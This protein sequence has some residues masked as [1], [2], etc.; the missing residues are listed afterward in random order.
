ISRFIIND[1]L[2]RDKAVPTPFILPISATI[3]KTHQQ[4][5]AYDEILETFSRAFMRHYADAW[6]FGPEKAAEDGVRHNLQFDAWEDARHAWR[7]PDLTRHAEYL[8]DIVRRTLEDD[9]RHEADQLHRLRTARER[10]KQILEGPD[11]DIDRIIRSVRENDGKVSRKLTKEFPA[12]D[13]AQVSE[14][15]GKII[16]DIFDLN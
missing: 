15:I 13:D 3:T 1:T 9:M 11:Q 7:Y 4:R 5:Q 2:R 8:A 12:L 16:R 6:S 10:I 14:E